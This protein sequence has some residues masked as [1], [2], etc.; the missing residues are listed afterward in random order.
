ME[1]PRAKSLWTVVGAVVLS[2]ALVALYC[3]DPANGGLYP[4]CG[5]HALTG[6]NCPACGSL[7]ALHHLLHGGI[8]AAFKCNPLL[9]V[10]LPIATVFLGR[11]LLAER[12]GLSPVRPAN[13]HWI[14]ILLG[15]LIVFGILRNLP[16][17]AFA[18]MSP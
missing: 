7:R 16:F 8:A 1:S 5:F 12:N 2:L 13:P 4:R 11:R 14:W 15:V 18:W 9:V 6:L 17:A 10:L 3:F